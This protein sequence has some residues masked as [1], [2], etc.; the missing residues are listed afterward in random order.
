MNR[1]I[2]LKR[3]LDVLKDFDSDIIYRYRF[4][5][6]R[7]LEYISPSSA[8]IIG[9]T[10]EELYSDPDLVVKIIHPEDRDNLKAEALGQSLVLRFLHKDGEVI[11]VE[12]RGKP[13][14]DKKGRLTAVEGIIRDISGRRKAE[15]ALCECEDRY[16]RLVNSTTDYIYSVMIEDGRPVSTKHGPG[17]LA[18]TGYATEEYD[19]DPFLWFSMVHEEDRETVIRHADKV[20]SGE[21]LQH[22]EHRL[23]H[24]NGTVI[25]VRNTPVPRYDQ[26]G[27]L[28]SYD[29]LIENITDRKRAEEALRDS[30]KRLRDII[31]NARGFI[32]VKDLNGRFLIINQYTEDSLGRSRDRI[33]GRTVFDL[34]PHEFA[35]AYTGNDRQVLDSGR[36][37]EFEEAAPLKDGTHSFISVKFPLRDS[38]GHIYGLG[39]MCTDITERKKL[40]EQLR[41]SQKMEAIGLLA[42]G[43]AHDFNNILTAIIGYANIVKMKTEKDSPVKGNLDQII[44]SSERG[45]H[46]TRSLLAFSRK[47]LIIPRPLDLNIIIR[48]VQKLLSRVISED[49]DMQVV[50]DENPVLILADSGQIEQI[51]MNLATNARDAMP[52][53]GTLTIKT[54]IKAIGEQF[55]REHG[56]GEPD[57]YALLSIA[58]TGAGM[59]EKTRERIFEPFFTTKEVGR[60]T[61]LGLAMVY[62]SVKQNNGY[63]TVTSELGKGTVFYIY[64]PLIKTAAGYEQ[65]TR[66]VSLI[67]GGTETVLLAEDD[68]PL[69]KLVSSVLHEFGYTVIEAKDGLDAIERFTDHREE[70]RLAILDVIMPRKNGKEVYEE[71][72]RIVPG[73]KTLFISGYTAEIMHARGILDLGLNFLSKP[74]MPD[75]LLNKVREI[76]DAN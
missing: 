24:K 17:C 60:G 61:G 2:S 15:Y 13:V 39:A 25:W 7:G 4:L 62:G 75:Q 50:L 59:D 44:A 43:V 8:G 68:E 29:G 20:L 57:R 30:E 28:T 66:P 5:P 40:E 51:L 58:D 76:L 73:M 74:I 54:E 53:G 38:Q 18:V 37:M 67:K 35:Q 26:E 1:K 72:I 22:L 55:I 71:I 3:I 36:A 11:W 6:V 52:H 12:Q 69:R 70:V 14:Y 41:Q 46:L 21:G 31:D 45:A 19:A 42:G 47:Q 10:P 56:F 65:K 23:I 33:I 27:R 63:I 9:Y 64:L 34:F 32:W 48:N 16:R 49:I